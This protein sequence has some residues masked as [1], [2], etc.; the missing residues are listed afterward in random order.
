MRGVLGSGCLGYEEIQGLSDDLVPLVAKESFCGRIH[1]A[2]APVSV[3]NDCGV[4]CRINDA[5]EP[6]LLALQAD[7]PRLC[8]ART[9]ILSCG[10]G[11]LSFEVVWIPGLGDIRENAAFVDGPDDGGQVSVGSHQDPSSR[12]VLAQPRKQ[13]ITR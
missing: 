12:R 10:G 4:W 13:L 3:D 7:L 8:V 2:D 1:E 11:Y 6:L 5:A 9:A